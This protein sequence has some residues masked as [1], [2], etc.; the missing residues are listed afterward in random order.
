MIVKRL[1]PGQDLKRALEE[2]RDEKDL[3]SGVIICMVGSLDKAVLRMANG[4]NNIISG[5][6]EIISATGTIATDGVHIHLA[7]SDSEGVVTGG[8]LMSGSQVHTTVE[9][10]ILTS[11]KIFKREFDSETG[12]NELIIID[13]QE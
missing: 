1:I 7:V 11:D 3:K 2:I 6:L 9:L 4:D 13:K 10:C 5:P 8:H 12:Y